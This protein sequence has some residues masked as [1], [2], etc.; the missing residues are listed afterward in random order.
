M[1]LFAHFQRL[2]PSDPLLVAEV[3]A[4]K[5]DG[6]SLL[7]TPA[8]GI[9]RARGTNVP[10]GTNAYVQSGRVIEEAPALPVYNETV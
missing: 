1:N 3:I 8:G 7:E 6:S 9:I 10:V 2:L 5:T 4:H